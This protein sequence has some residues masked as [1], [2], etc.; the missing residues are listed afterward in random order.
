DCRSRRPRP[1][2]D[3]RDVSASPLPRHAKPDPRSSSITSTAT[4]D[5]CAILISSVS[6]HV[7]RSRRGLALPLREHSCLG[8]TALEQRPAARNGTKQLVGRIRELPYAFL[9]QFFLC[10]LL[11]GNAVVL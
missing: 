8:A 10:D 4:K 1:R 7:R 3:R 5:P 9:D 11:Q 2:S 6:F